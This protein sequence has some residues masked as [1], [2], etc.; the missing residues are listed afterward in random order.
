MQ[1]DGSYQTPFDTVHETLKIMEDA[2]VAAD[3]KGQIFVKLDMDADS[4]YK[5]DKRDFNKN[6][7]VIF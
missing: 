4:F 7:R 2:I 1:P 3:L 5:A 6:D